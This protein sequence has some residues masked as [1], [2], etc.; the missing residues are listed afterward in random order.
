MNHPESFS[1]LAPLA[2]NKHPLENT[3]SN[4]GGGWQA[5][6]EITPKAKK[7]GTLLVSLSGTGRARAEAVSAGAGRGM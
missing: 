1:C 7:E 6:Q 4:L 2:A 3:S 5:F